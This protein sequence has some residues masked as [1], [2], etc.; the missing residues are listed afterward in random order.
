M[1]DSRLGRSETFLASGR[2]RWDQDNSTEHRLR[3]ESRYLL[4]QCPFVFGS[5]KVWARRRLLDNMGRESC[6]RDA[7]R[8]HWP[9]HCRR[10]HKLAFRSAELFLHFWFV[11]EDGRGAQLQHGE[12]EIDFFASQREQS[13][14]TVIVKVSRQPGNLRQCSKRDLSVGRLLI[15]SRATQR[16]SHQRND[17]PSDCASG[18]QLDTSADES[19]LHRTVRPCSNECFLAFHL[20]GVLVLDVSLWLAN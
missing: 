3:L 16:I 12:S 7:L 15:P 2:L 18:L 9:L 14:E 17:D 10:L 6:L 4:V 19:R 13:M 1:D 11:D 8:A 5:R 20:H